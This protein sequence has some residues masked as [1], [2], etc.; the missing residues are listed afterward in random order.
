MRL[1][2]T[3]KGLKLKKN[4]FEITGQFSLYL[5]YKGLKLRDVKTRGLEVAVYILLIKD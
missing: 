4:G 2:L 1:Y 3:Y 5:T